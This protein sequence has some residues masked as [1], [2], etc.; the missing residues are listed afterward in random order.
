MRI[1]L[2]V[3]L[4]GLAAGSGASSQSPAQPVPQLNLMPMPSSL[5]LGSGALPVSASFSVAIEGHR[6]P[7]LERAVERFCRD[8]SRRTGLFIGVKIVDASKATLV[9]HVERA[10]KPVQDLREDESYV[11]DV[12]A[13]GAKLTAQNPLGVM[14]G[15]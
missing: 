3:V 12:D 11:L 4:L 10:S 15:L 5:Q 14:H 2:F 13:S 9:I 8:L 1:R 7:R 6:E